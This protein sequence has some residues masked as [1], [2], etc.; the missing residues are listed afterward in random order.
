MDD[1][2]KFSSHKIAKLFLVLQ[3]LL[4][5]KQQLIFKKE[6]ATSLREQEDVLWHK[7]ND[8]KDD[9][10]CIIMMKFP[11]SPLKYITY[12][13]F[14]KIIPNLTE[15]KEKGYCKSASHI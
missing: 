4:S 6:I 11:L 5:N 12:S 1:A 15:M 14:N 8:G 10:G 3:L 9:D 2:R 7:I 13:Y